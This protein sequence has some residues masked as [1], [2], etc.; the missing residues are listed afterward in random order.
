MQTPLF[1]LEFQR[2]GDCWVLTPSLTGDEE[3]CCEGLG[4]LFDIP[5]TCQKIELGVFEEP[6]EGTHQI[7]GFSGNWDEFEI[8]GSIVCLAGALAGI[9]RDY[10]HAPYLACWHHE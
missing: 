5:E 1:I 9:L 6:D 2:Q 10:R 7:V 8:G 3:F 4:Q